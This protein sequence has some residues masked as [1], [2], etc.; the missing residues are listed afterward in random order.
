MRNIFL[1]AIG[2]LVVVSLRS[3]GLD[4]PVSHLAVGHSGPGY[5]SQTAAFFD[6]R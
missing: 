4:C 5:E 1:V 3:H 2:I 6:M